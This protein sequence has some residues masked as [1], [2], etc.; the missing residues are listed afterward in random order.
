MPSCIFFI[1]CLVRVLF[2]EFLG[3]RI[4]WMDQGGQRA[5]YYSLFQLWLFPGFK[6]AIFFV[7]LSNNDFRTYIWTWSTQTPSMVLLLL[8]KG[9]VYWMNILDNFKTLFLFFYTLLSLVSSM[10]RILSVFYWIRADFLELGHQWDTK[11]TTIMKKA[12]K[13]I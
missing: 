9:Q 7:K 1:A 11:I 6:N 12:F 5:R 4:R 10:A 8:D 2:I 3:S 13:S